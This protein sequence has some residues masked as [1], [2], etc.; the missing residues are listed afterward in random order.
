MIKPSWSTLAAEALAESFPIHHKS[1]CKFWQA[2]EDLEDSDEAIPAIESVLEDSRISTP[3]L[4][5]LLINK[6]FEIGME[7]VR[8]HRNKTCVCFRSREIDE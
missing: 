3:A 6:G 8:V 1:R 4:H 2:V 7:S 5:K